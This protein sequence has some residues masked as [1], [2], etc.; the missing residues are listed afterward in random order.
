[1]RS[2]STINRC[3]VLKRT[4]TEVDILEGRDVWYEELKSR[5]KL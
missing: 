5:V 2:T 4:N 3:I 1:M